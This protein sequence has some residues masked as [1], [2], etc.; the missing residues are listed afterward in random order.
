MHKKL[1]K[2]IFFSSA[3]LCLLLMSSLALAA[4]KLEVNYPG[5]N[6]DNIDLPSFIKYVYEFFII[7]AGVTALW[8]LIQGG[9]LYLA[10]AGNPGMMEEAKNQIIAVF[11]GVILL[12]ASY[13]ILVNINPQ[14]ISLNLPGISHPQTSPVTFPTPSLPSSDL[15]M[16]L[17]DMADTIKTLPDKIKKNA[18]D[19]KTL[20]D[21]CDCARTRS[22]CLCNGGEA[23]ASCEAKWCYVGPS[24]GNNENSTASDQNSAGNDQNFWSDQG[25][26]T[27]NGQDQCNKQQNQTGAHPCPDAVK[28][29]SLQKEIVDWRDV[30]LFYKIRALA[31]AKDLDANITLVLD[32]KISFYNALIS[33]EQARDIISPA[34]IS[35]LQQ[36][37]QKIQ[38]EKQYKTQLIQE[39]KNLATAL[40]KVEAPTTE[41]AGLP[42]RCL[43]DVGTKCKPSCLT[44]SAYGCHDKLC[45][46]QPDK[47]SGGNP[48]PVSE[49]QNQAGQINSLPGE[50]TGIC[51]KIINI[52]GQIK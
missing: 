18:E 36:E 17:K 22:L 38:Q 19:I 41:I 44:G 13:L 2:T 43:S 48:C 25:T 23:N 12:L 11:W 42:D 21:K 51:D 27:G 6:S 52:T 28:I 9:V 46:C 35:R 37:L 20:T 39:L 40:A 47:C 29:S 10:S 24:S 26:G 5:L 14:L 30:I 49:I 7:G 50:I 34:M 31:E 1:L 32:K 8:Y 4:N 45:G 3:S 33:Q 15:L 16:R